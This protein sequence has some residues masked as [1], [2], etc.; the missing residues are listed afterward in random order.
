M[1]GLPAFSYNILDKW[2][3]RLPRWRKREMEERE[4]IS[5]QRSCDP[6]PCEEIWEIEGST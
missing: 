5:I 1:R 4:V 2:P 3:A 6:I